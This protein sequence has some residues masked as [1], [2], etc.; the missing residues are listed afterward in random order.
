M[1]RITGN[2]VLH[3]GSVLAMICKSLTENF[4]RIIYSL[5]RKSLFLGWCGLKTLKKKTQLSF[6]WCPFLS[7]MGKLG[8]QAEEEISHLPRSRLVSSFVNR[9]LNGSTKTISWIC[10]YIHIY[11]YMLFD[12]I[13]W[14]FFPAWLYMISSILLMELWDI[15][16]I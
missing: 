2:W 13:W 5:I 12:V 1:G 3:A 6:L 11:I 16:L 14:T 4:I 10:N 9:D 8:Q 7:D 15:K